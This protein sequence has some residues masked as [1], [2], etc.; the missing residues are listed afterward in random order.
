MI[1]ADGVVDLTAGQVRKPLVG[2][3]CLPR[4]ISAPALGTATLLVASDGLL[5][6]AKAPDIARLARGPSPPLRGP[7]SSSCASP[8]ARC[9]TTSASSCAVTYVTRERARAVS[10]PLLV[11]CA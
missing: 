10:Q 1:A 7:S 6:Y 9:R 5:R 8:T 3:G 4:P 11:P 2:D